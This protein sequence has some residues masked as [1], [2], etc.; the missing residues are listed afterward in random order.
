MQVCYSQSMASFNDVQLTRKIERRLQEWKNNPRHKAL[1]IEG[2]R[3]VGK[4]YSIKH[5]GE[6]NY[7]QVISLN[8]EE[9]PDYK[10]IFQGS[11]S[12]DDVFSRLSLYQPVQIDQGSESTD[13]LLF[14]DEIQSC[15]DAITAL[16]FLT[17]D[18][19]ADVIATGSLL[20]VSYREVSSYPVGY[21]DHMRMNSLDFEE[22]LWANGVEET[23]IEHVR[24]FYERHEKVPEAVNGRMLQLFKEYI[25]VGG[26]PE[27]VSIFLETKDYAKVLA[28]Q[29]DI[30]TEYRND[31]AKYA[32][33]TGKAKARACFDSIPKQLARDYKKFTYSVV[34]PRSSARKYA[35]S[36]QWL[37]DAGIINFCYRLENPELPFEGNTDNTKFK[38]YMRD[39]GLLVSMLEEGSQKDILDGKLGICK[40]A[41]FE[42]V[43]A[44]VFA[45]NGKR[46]HYYERN[47][48][49]EM[50][51]FIRLGDEP[52]AIEVKSSPNR[53]AKSMDTIISGGLVKRGLKL[54]TGN[55]GVVREGVET[56]PI[57][58]AMFL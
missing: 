48:S 57:Y 54:A 33:G 46:L 8:F 45:K 20:G 51:F 17:I 50:D 19:R 26:M 32:D 5:F 18:G 44:D 3:Q 29:Q 43:V 15:P 14:L 28:A 55:Y 56:L 24:G 36:L 38:V 11:K 10:G 12:A 39:T 42:N 21:V 1:I 4:T 58:M 25:V 30:V 27:A 22:F 35:G 13:L 41:I 52:V 16:K 7:K 2:A 40:G 31:I 6:T 47:N 9:N 37:Y 34:E 49:L 23:S 53:K